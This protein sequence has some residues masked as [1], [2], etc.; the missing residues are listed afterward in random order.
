MDLTGHRPLS[1]CAAILVALL[2]CVGIDAYA[3]SRWHPDILGDGYVCTTVHQPS[4]YGGDVTCTVVRHNAECD[5]PD[6]LRRGVLY[7]HGYNDYFFQKDMGDRFIDSGYAFYA[8]DLRRYGRSILPYRRPYE[9]RNIAEYYADIDS[10]LMLMHQNGV[11]DIVLMGHSTGGLVAASYLNTRHDTEIRA[12]VLNSP[13]LEWNMG[14][15]MR[16][17]AIPMVGC[18]GRH[19]PNI[20]ISQGDG[21]A[22]AESLLKQYHGQWEFNTDW[23]TIHPRKVTAGWIRAISE[24][25]DALHR[26]SW[27]TVPILLMSSGHSVYGDKWTPEH[28]HGDAVL[29][30]EDIRRYGA[31]LGPDVKSYKFEGGLHDLILSD[32]PVADTVYRTIFDWL[33]RQLP[34]QPE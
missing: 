7:I 4:D 27:I 18:L 28:Q 14:G 25:Q 5:T 19:F 34:P 23:K 30:V 31:T 2:V 1:V 21:T 20:A 26:H 15:F 13:F 22:Y 11:R 9:V 33:A 8:V 17:V 12:L 32:R 29:N 3:A 6:T 16:H 10:A 24:A